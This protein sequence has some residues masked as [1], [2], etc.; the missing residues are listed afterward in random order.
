MG[1]LGELAAVVA[2]GPGRGRGA[3]AGVR[4]SSPEFA[5]AAC[6]RGWEGKEEVAAGGR[7]SS[8]L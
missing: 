7:V 3:M 6:G 4:R 1:D 8:E 2:A 5:M